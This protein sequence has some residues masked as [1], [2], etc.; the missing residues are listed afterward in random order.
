[1]PVIDDMSPAYNQDSCQFW[2][3][4]LENARIQ[5]YNY[6]LAINALAV[7]NHSSYELNTGQGSQRVTR[8]DLP[9]LTKMQSYLTDR[10]AS[11]EIKLGKRT[12]TTQFIPGF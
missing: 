1:M 5:L 6:N 10:I 2:Q 3:D 4:E 9:S 7:G 12:G 11:I 8:L